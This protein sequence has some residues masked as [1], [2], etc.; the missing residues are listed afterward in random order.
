MFM[1][2]DAQIAT[3]ISDAE[4]GRRWRLIRDDM[5]EAGIDAL[6]M[7]STNDWLGGYVKWFTDIPATN[8]YPR[9]VIFYRTELM[10]VV[11]MGAFGSNRRLNGDD[12]VNRGVGLVRQTPSFLSIDYT[13][14]YDAELVISDIKSKGCRNVGIVN[15]G[16]IAH[17]FVGKI[18]SELSGPC[19]VRDATA[20][21]D[22]R[23]AVKSDEEA[24]LIRQTAQM[25][26]A[27]FDKVLAHIQPGQRDIDITSFAQYVAQRLGSE[28]GILLGAPARVGTISRFVGRHFQNAIFAKGDHISL[29]IEV[30]GPGGF[31][32]E[33]ARTIVLGKASNQLMDAFETVREAQQNTLQQIRPGISCREVAANHNDYMTNRGRPAEM[34]LYAH[35]QGY[36]MVERPLIRADETMNIEEGMCLAIHPGYETPEL[37]AVICDNYMVEA[38]GPGNCLHKTA[39]QIFEI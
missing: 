39:K 3:R 29:L 11:E 8:G 14:S 24:S 12:P 2:A 13:Q 19:R 15:S 35:G 36:D 5:A 21:V 34:R 16:G 20:L 33:L 22:R 10:T 32:T 9:S 27:V 25:Q 31:Y 18:K 28:Q 6:V 26:D 1:D 7:Q 4:L 30:N 17:G 37:F 23:K 38:N